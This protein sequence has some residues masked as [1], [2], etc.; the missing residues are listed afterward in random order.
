M[1][2]SPDNARRLLEAA[3]H[4]ERR[5][6]ELLLAAAWSLTRGQLLAREMDPVPAGV[7]ARFAQQVEQ[8]KQ[9]GYPVQEQ[10]L[11]HVWPTR[12]RHINIYGKYHFN[13]EEEWKRHGLR[14]LRQPGVVTP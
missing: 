14:P 8:R 11:A 9:E 2:D 4:V 6:A 13:V 7:A 5:D 12:Y 1:P 10:D 3:G